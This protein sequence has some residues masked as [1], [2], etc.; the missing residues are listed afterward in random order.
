V[1]AADRLRAV[2]CRANVAMLDIT[3]AWQGA[4]R[5]DGPTR[6]ATPLV[7]GDVLDVEPQ[8]AAR[9]VVERFGGS[10]P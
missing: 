8:R 2:G 1:L 6:P 4:A 5:I 7:G 10:T 3:S 9:S